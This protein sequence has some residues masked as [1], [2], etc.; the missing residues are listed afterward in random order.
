MDLCGICD[1][2]VTWED[3][4]LICDHCELWVHA[5]CSKINKKQYEFH[6]KN[7]DDPFECM[8]CLQCKI[9]TRKIAK[10]QLPLICSTCNRKVH[11]KCNKFDKKNYDY[12]KENE[13]QFN[14]LDCLSDNLPFLKLNDKQF[15]LIRQGINYP[16]EADI[17]LL[18][19]SHTQMQILQQINAALERG[20]GESSND[21]DSEPPIDC[22]YYSIDQFNSKKFND[23]KHF[24]ILHLNI[25]SLTAHI[26]ELRIILQLLNLPFNFIC[27]T[28]TKIIK[29]IEPKIDISLSGYQDPVGTPTE[30]TK[31]GVLIYAKKGIDFKPRKDLCIY[32][33]KELE[34]FFI[35]TT[36][37]SGKNA[38]IGTIY[39]HPSMDPSIFTD[40]YL[41]PLNDK[42]VNEKKK[43]FI[44]GDFNFDLLQTDKSETF[45]F[46]E[47]MMAT[48]LLPTIT[49]P[50]K[51]NKKNSTIIDN[52][53]T[54]QI[55]PDMLSGNLTVGISDHLISF[56]IIPNDNQNHLP[57]KHNLYTRKTK[58]LD[59]INLILDYLDIDWDSKLKADDKNVNKT[60][61]IFFH[62]MNSLLDRYKPLLK[63]T[64]KEYKRKF[65]PWITDAI[66]EKID[67][68]NNIFQKY[69][70]CK[71]DVTKQELH[72][73]YTRQKNL[74]TSL[75]RQSEKQYYNNYFTTNKDNLQ[76]VW[77]G[78]KEIINIKSKSHSHP[79]CIIDNDHTITDPT[80]IANSFNKYYSSIASNILKKR[81]YN[82]KEHFTKYLSNPN[83]STI[84]IYDC[85]QKEVLLL[86]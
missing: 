37:T 11:T 34:S 85:D 68:K 59:R 41:Q 10:H 81:K 77:K 50:T 67:K 53:F 23:T 64:Q 21:D 28:E 7:E 32:Q 8:R 13:S 22:K 72:R 75:T 44:A 76:K 35:E 36:N 57:K 70:N 31:G 55:N 3:D 78:I 63:V 33:P 46:F 74:V 60:T 1:A 29:D 56:F 5:K 66:L 27:I 62:E 6:V 26:S 58:N 39:R 73:Q 2:E 42:L 82:G 24:A 65:K 45:A 86:F 17:D 14:C 19:L 20:I 61:N 15:H 54:N 30:A 9:C 43:I 71:D 47:N 12:F 49:I 25:H 69:I 79:N 4:A 16:D 18:D 51:I 48:H 80:K 84:A 38:I 40:D 52:I 83:P